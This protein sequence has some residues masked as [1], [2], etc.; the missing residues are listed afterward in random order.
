VLLEYTVVEPSGDH[1]WT[2][3]EI[4][5]RDGLA[6]LVGRSIEYI[7]AADLLLNGTS[8]EAHRHDGNRRIFVLTETESGYV[9]LR[10]IQ[11]VVFRS[12]GA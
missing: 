9:L 5:D 12:G 4:L 11:M 1:M 8:W 7:A 6:D 10:A 2:Q 3:P